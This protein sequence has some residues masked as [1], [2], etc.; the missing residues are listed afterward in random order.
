MPKKTDSGNSQDWLFFAGED[1]NAVSLLLE[2]QTSFYVCRSKLA[3]ALEKCLKADLIFRGWELRKIHDLQ[4][5]LDELVASNCAYSKKLQSLVDE[6]AEC[7][8][9]DRYPGFD[10]DDPDWISLQKGYKKIKQF[11]LGL[12]RKIIPKPRKGKKS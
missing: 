5:L 4:K 9:L 11:F 3:E 12:E 10:L 1:L 7:Y 6:F 2:N 8:T